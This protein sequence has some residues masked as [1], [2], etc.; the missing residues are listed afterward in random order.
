MGLL[1][2]QESQD[3]EIQKSKV[4]RSS[5][6]VLVQRENMRHRTKNYNQWRDMM[7]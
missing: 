3:M 6:H 7:L 1:Q 2:K 5:T 4:M